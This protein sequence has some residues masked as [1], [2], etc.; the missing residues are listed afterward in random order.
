MLLKKRTFILEVYIEAD[1]LFYKGEVNHGKKH[2]QKSEEE[3]KKILT[4]DEFLMLRK[5]GTELP[6]SGKYVHHKAN[7][8][9]ACA[10]CGAELFSSETKFDSGS[11][12][13]SFFSSVPDDVLL[14]KPDNSLGMRRTE[15]VC[16]R[17]KG[18]LGHMFDDGPPPTE[19]RYCINSAALDF[20]EK[21]T[22]KLSK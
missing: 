5:K 4:G 2:V 20:Q 3:W 22:K 10:G 1:L 21:N 14:L 7:G 17:C 18:H 19:K 12:W 9:Y 6:F 11:G 16:R 13:P 15:V 8:V